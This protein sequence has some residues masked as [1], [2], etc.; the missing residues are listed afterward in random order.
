MRMETNDD[1][2]F[3]ADAPLFPA[4]QA[5]TPA[6]SMK[7]MAQGGDAVKK[8]IAVTGEEKFEHMLLFCLKLLDQA[9]G[10]ICA[11]YLSDFDDCDEHTLKVIEKLISRSG[12]MT[13]PYM[14]GKEKKNYNGFWAWRKK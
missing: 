2:T 4:G 11:F 12:Y 3:I 14:E 7:L 10:G 6:D 1:E 8:C 5:A 9:K 13:S